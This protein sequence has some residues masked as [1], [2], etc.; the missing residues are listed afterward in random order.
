M[1]TVQSDTSPSA[2]AN[3]EYKDVNVSY[4]GSMNGVAERVLLTFNQEE[5]YVIK[6]L[7]AQFRYIFIIN[8][9]FY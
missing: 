8:L 4:K 2:S 5:Q 3:V 6:V 1:P 9:G 7:L